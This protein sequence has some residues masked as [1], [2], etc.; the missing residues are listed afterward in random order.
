M[1][2][3]AKAVSWTKQWYIQGADTVCNQVILW[4]PFCYPIAGY[5]M[6]GHFC[7]KLEKIPRIK[8]KFCGTRAVI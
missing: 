6:D 2:I 7:E 1:Q 3:L 8:F 5:F 4:V